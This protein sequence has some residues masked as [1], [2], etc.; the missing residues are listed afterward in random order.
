MLWLS[1]LSW[2]DRQGRKLGNAGQPG[3]YSYADFAL[4]TDGTRLAA[5]K[6]DP[7]MGQGETGI[8]LLDLLRGVSTRLTFDL[9]PDSAAVWSPDGSRVAFAAYRAGGYGIYQKATNGAGKE[10]ELVRATGDRGSRTIGR[11]TGDSCSTPSGTLELM[12]IYG[13]CLWRAMEQR[14]G[15]PHLLQIRSTARD[16]ADSLPMHTG[17]LMRRT[18]PVDPKSIFNLFRR[19]RTAAA[20][21][22]SPVMVA[23]SLAGV[24]MARNCSM[25]PLTEN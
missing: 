15:Q 2:F 11:V 14:L 18:S 23:A 20:R 9:S 7:R 4:S 25:C 1:Q 10:Q 12:A 24:G 3:T 21:R 16:K 6:V 13:S 19:P 8:W 17:S 22:R 5:S